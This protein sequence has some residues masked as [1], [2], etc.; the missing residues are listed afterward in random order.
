MGHRMHTFFALIVAHTALLA[1][2]AFATEP[3]C[4]DDMPI[5]S[6]HPVDGGYIL[7]EGAS[8]NVL[9]VAFDAYWHVCDNRDDYLG[10]FERRGDEIWISQPGYPEGEFAKFALCDQLPAMTSRCIPCAF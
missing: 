2:P 6:I 10:H 5:M 3:Y 8:N 9:C 1:S 4:S 7:S